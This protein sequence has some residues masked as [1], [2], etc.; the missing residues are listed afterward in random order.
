MIKNK[1]ILILV[2]GIIFSP[3]FILNAAEPI[4]KTTAININEADVQLQKEQKIMKGS[5]EIR[6]A[7]LK[8]KI[9]ERKNEKKTTLKI[10]AQRRIKVLLDKIFV[11]LNDR[12]GKIVILDYNFSAKIATFEKEGKDLSEIKTEYNIAKLELTR[13]Q[14]SISAALILSVEQ[15]KAGT[16]K[17]VIRDLVKATQESIKTAG[18]AYLKLLP[19]LIKIEGSNKTKK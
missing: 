15:I 16:S 3:L 19:L 7:I 11:N 18:D 2:I 1:I 10:E 6:K 13:A 14:A 8:T 9:N 17:G 12:L 4:N 5:V